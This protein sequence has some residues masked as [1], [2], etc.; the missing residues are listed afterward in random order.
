MAINFLLEITGR[1]A[2]LTFNRPEKRHP[3]NEE[4][5]LE[6][7]GILHQVRDDKNVRVMILTGSGNTFAAAPTCRR[8]EASPTSASGTE[9]SRQSASSGCGSPAASYRCW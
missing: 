6:M 3:V 9:S 2:T 8:L 7:E 4:S 1:I 5:L